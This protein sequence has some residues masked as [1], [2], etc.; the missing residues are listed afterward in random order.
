[1]AGRSNKSTNQ[2]ASSNDAIRLFGKFIVFNLVSPYRLN[3]I[4]KYSDEQPSREYFREFVNPFSVDIISL[5][6]IPVIKNCSTC[7]RVYFPICGDDNKTYTNEC[8]LNCVNK[9]YTNR[10]REVKKVRSGPLSTF[11]LCISIVT[12]KPQRYASPF[13]I[14][15]YYMANITDPLPALEKITNCRCP[16]IYIPVCGTDNRTYTNICWM[17]CKNEKNEK[18][19]KAVT[20]F[21]MGICLNFLDA[22]DCPKGHVVCYIRLLFPLSC[23]FSLL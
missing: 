11:L 17:N 10:T 23:F 16:R 3:R 5:D 2:T 13:E 12:S 1:M 20:V 14:Q 18:K 8:R 21:Y 22:F 19:R 6:K 15:D 4:P 9:F 7:P